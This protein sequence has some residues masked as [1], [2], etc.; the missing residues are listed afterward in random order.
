MSGTCKHRSRRSVSQGSS[1][2]HAEVIWGEEPRIRPGVKKHRL[3]A[4]LA[5]S[6][7]PRQAD[8]Y[9]TA[10]CLACGAEGD[11]RSGSSWRKAGGHT[12]PL[13]HEPRARIRSFQRHQVICRSA[14]SEILVVPAPAYSAWLE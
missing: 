3:D 13:R 7:L 10:P 6:D 14:P 1:D 11:E 12:P 5:A 8:R 9:R 2:P 4:Q